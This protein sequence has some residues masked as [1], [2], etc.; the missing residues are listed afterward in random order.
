MVRNEPKIRARW[1]VMD[2]KI[3]G[4]AEPD[5]PFGFYAQ[6]E[7]VKSLLKPPVGNHLIFGQAEQLKVMFIGGPNQRPDYHINEGEELF[8][9]LKGPLDLKIAEHNQPKIVR[10]EEGQMFCLPPRV[11]HSPQ[12]YA[13]TCGLVIERERLPTETDALRWLKILYEK[14]FHCYDLGTQL[15]PAIMEYLASEA[16]QTRLPPE[17]TP[18][19]DPPVKVDHDIVVPAPFNLASALTVQCVSGRTTSLELPHCTEFTVQICRAFS[20]SLKATFSHEKI[21]RELFLWSVASEE[22]VDSKCTVS[23]GIDKWELLAGDA[24]YVNANGSNFDISST[25]SPI[26]LVIYNSVYQPS[27]N[28]AAGKAPA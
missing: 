7:A 20:G 21:P 27:P 8:F 28:S 16:H 5:V 19:P 3:E 2:F 17:G 15:K 10:V 25:G 18:H 23:S 14:F 1:I 4:K 24:C 6:A 13:D 9:Q 12:R 11:P 26:L 22:S